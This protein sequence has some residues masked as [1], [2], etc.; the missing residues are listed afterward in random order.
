MITHRSDSIKE[1]QKKHSLEAAIDSLGKQLSKEKIENMK[2]D[3]TIAELGKR[4]SKL[5]IE[6]MKMK[7]ELNTIKQAL[8]KKGGE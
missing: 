7:N 1:L 5:S 6:F 4:E 3:K 2:K 8:D